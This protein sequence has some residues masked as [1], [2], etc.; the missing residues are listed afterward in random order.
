MRVNEYITSDKRCIMY[1]GIIKMISKLH[2]FV[3]CFKMHLRINFA[4]VYFQF[5][6][7]SYSLHFVEFRGVLLHQLRHWT[8]CES[9]QVVGKRFEGLPQNVS[10]FFLSNSHRMVVREGTVC[11]G[12]ITAHSYD[13][14]DS[15]CVGGV[16]RGSQVAF[17]LWMDVTRPQ[18][19]GRVYGTTDGFRWF[20]GCST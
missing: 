19:G 7:R 8:D 20:V 17:L 11:F 9:I 18:S 5:Q 14:C 12:G 10:H 3:R 6:C 15:F 4:F 2:V 1:Q 13:H 16:S